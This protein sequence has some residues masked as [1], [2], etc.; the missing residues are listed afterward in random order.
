MLVSRATVVCLL[1][2]LTVRAV[3]GDLIQHQLKTEREYYSAHPRALSDELPSMAHAVRSCLTHPAGHDTSPFSSRPYGLNDAVH[4]FSARSGKIVLTGSPGSGMAHLVYLL[5]AATGLAVETRDDW[6]QHHAA[7]WSE[8]THAWAR[9]CG[10]SGLCDTTRR[11]S[12][13]ADDPIIIATS[14]PFDIH[15]ESGLS[16]ANKLDLYHRYDD[17]DLVVVLVRNPYDAMVLQDI[18]LSDSNAFMEAWSHH[19]DYWVLRES[20]VPV[21]IVRFEDVLRTPEWVIG[22]IMLLAGLH[23]DLSLI[24][25]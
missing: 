23:T 18:G 16:V 10:W 7:T 13:Q 4:A 1:A 2:A 12:Q 9:P 3:T 25:I 5:E 19:A 22:R 24:H 20:A 8:Y 6:A 14:F 17:A 15:G 21:V 11:S